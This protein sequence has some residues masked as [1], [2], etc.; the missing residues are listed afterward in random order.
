MKERPKL[1]KLLHLLVALAVAFMIVPAKPVYADADPID[2]FVMDAET[3]PDGSIGVLFVR[4]GSS[5]D[6]VISGG[7]LWYGVF[8][9][10]GDLQ[11]SEEAVGSETGAKEAALAI[12][13]GRAHIAYTTDNNTI[14]YIYQTDNGWSEPTEFGSNNVYSG[15]GTVS[16]PDIVIGSDGSV[17]IAYFDTEGYESEDGKGYPEVM[18]AVVGDTVV[19]SVVFVGWGW[20]SSPDG[21]R[22][23]PTTPVKIVQTAADYVNVYS[24]TFW[25][26]YYG[27]S[28]TSYYV[29]FT[30]IGGET[31]EI[32]DD[33][34]KYDIYEACSNGSD[35]Y[36]LGYGRG[37][38][39][40]LVY[41]GSG[42]DVMGLKSDAVGNYAADMTL[43]GSGT[44]YYSAANGNSILF[45]QNG[46]A[47]VKALQNPIS[48]KKL[49]TVLSDGIQY[50]IFTN[51][52]GNIVVA[53]LDDGE[54]VELLPTG[55]IP[56]D[57]SSVS[58]TATGYDSGEI[59]GVTAGGGYVVSY[60]TSDGVASRS[61]L[62]MGGGETIE[63]TGLVP[64]TV[65]VIKKAS[66]E[67]NADSAPK[68][69]EITRADTPALVAAQPAVIDG[70]GSIP[71]DATH[72]YTTDD[73]DDEDAQWESCTGE[74]TDLEPGTYYVRVAAS[75]TV[76]TSDPQEIELVDFDPAQ[77]D[78]P[79][80]TFTATGSSSGTL[81]G[82]VSG[83]TYAFDD[84][85]FTVEAAASSYDM[86]ELSPG[87]YSLVKC[88]N[89]ETTI[90][91]DEQIFTIT[92]AS[93][94]E[95][96]G[97]NPAAIGGN[98][99]INTDNTHEYVTADPGDDPDAADWTDCGGVLEVGAGTYYIRVK[100]DQTAL[101]SNYVTVTLTDPSQEVTPAATFTAT[102]SAKGTLSG[103]IAGNYKISLG[104]VDSTFVIADGVTTHDLT[105]LSAGKLMLVRLGDN[106][107]TSV[108]SIPQ[109]ITI[110]K[111]DTPA[112]SRVNPSNRGRKGSIPTTAAYEYRSESPQ[113]NP[114]GVNWI[115][116]AGA[117]TGLEAGDYYIRVAASQTTLASDVQHI[118][119]ETENIVVVTFDANGH[120][121]AP[122]PVEIKS[123]DMVPEPDP[124]PAA[125]GY[126]FGGWYTQSECNEEHKWTFTTR[127]T[128]DSTFYAKWTPVS[129]TVKFDKNL[130]AATGSMEDQARK[131]DDGI[132]LTACT[133][134]GPEGLEFAGW[135]LVPEGTGTIY[136]DGAVG[137][138]AT[139]DGAKVTLYATWTEE[140]WGDIVP[141]D[142]ADLK[143]Q[144]IRSNR[145]PDGVWVGK[146]EDVP[147]T[148]GNITLSADQLHVYDGK[149]LLTEG[150]DYTTRYSNQKNVGNTAKV[151]MIG[152]GNYGF[153]YYKEFSIVPTALLTGEPFAY[154]I[155]DMKYK[156]GT[157][158]KSKPTIKF[159]RLTLKE[160]TDY[161][162]AYDPENPVDAGE[163]KVT[164]T[165]ISS[166]KDAVVITYHIVTAETTL[167]N[168][169]IE[170]DEAYPLVYRGPD[171]PV[172]PPV[173]VKLNKN[174]DG[175]IP[176]TDE[177]TGKP[178][179]E[180][181]YDKCDN[182]GKG[183]VWVVGK[184]AYGGSKSITITI[185]P[186]PLSLHPE[187][188]ANVLVTGDTSY[189]G[190]AI[191]PEIE[192]LD[193]FTAVPATDYSVTY[194][195]NTNRAS[196]TETTAA[197]KDIA[198]TVTVKLKGNYSGTLTKKFAITG[199][200]LAGEDLE[201][202]VP[203]VKLSKANQ[204]IT[205]AMIKPTV[206]YGKKTLKKGTD[207]SVDFA[208]SGGNV[209]VAMITLQGNYANKPGV[210]HIDKPFR[211]YQA[212]DVLSEAD[213]TFALSGTS[214]TYTGDKI[215]PAVT[216]TAADHQYQG[217]ALKLV[218]GRD[219]TVS[220]S[221]NVNASVNAPANKQPTV[222]VKGKGAYK[223]TLTK[224]F[225]IVPID[226]DTLGVD[227]WSVSVPDVK[228]TGKQLSPKVT[229]T[230]KGK[231]LKAADYSLA[232]EDTTVPT[233][234]EKAKVTVTFASNYSG[235]KEGH[236]RVYKTDIT[237]MTFEKIADRYYTGTSVR[238]GENDSPQFNAGNEIKIYK[239]NKKNAA[240]ALVYGVDYTLE[241]EENIA[242]GRGTVYIIGIGEY[243]NRKA[244]TFKIKQRNSHFTA[245]IYSQ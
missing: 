59:G 129:Y 207:Y 216:I 69:F 90:D 107:V 153:N 218:E 240:D 210:E 26:K 37:N 154:T 53:Y 199:L 24:T 175:Y 198:P 123:G 89:Y 238:P 202:T 85:E 155:K 41:N 221:N 13:D 172:H 51:T 91:S 176:L 92:K 203:D 80:A 151:T 182:A 219:Y 192:V 132:A 50:S 25:E 29:D 2:G 143:A 245:R 127:L 34:K 10:D 156:A 73:P 121:T 96:T 170:L 61:F 150:V 194:K 74:L 68:E 49:T 241:W 87:E 137:N 52:D 62:I 159:G 33:W 177:E 181:L 71:T 131:Y 60:P 224:N 220:Y 104:G 205:A 144:N 161:S 83:A 204:Q 75:D 56:E 39:A 98:G 133:F 111:A 20:F 43:D 130:A 15:G 135:S 136:F 36:A 101:A 84:Y 115:A 46:A 122:A 184:N 208:H 213:F 128:G 21:N 169:V 6:G 239:T 217:A 23:F 95:L 22:N 244:L 206:K 152:K 214:F 179:Y 45:D 114:D 112:L 119:L 106:G 76:L 116:C 99:S 149:K 146:I 65:S 183:T 38:Y 109:E 35:V 212:Q 12:Y 211:A 5:S 243:G 174:S 88:G 79:T 134:E 55:L 164:V 81:S 4:G 157:V 222:T 31:K 117:L 110:T 197:G 235:T 223:G 42:A 105:G 94:P 32:C 72:E 227:E 237:R 185:A 231:T 124:A 47:V 103:L 232:Y 162:L 86:T 30:P 11:W 195:N 196:A 44:I 1:K 27:G 40:I 142:V 193:G 147:F 200:Q 168:A 113:G 78:T 236:F 108:D 229:V 64:G 230:V 171:N 226:V 102:G 118:T 125:T 54:L 67:I 57:V 58:F 163:V 82:L 165:G 188:V 166:F 126:I 70:K 7:T 186:K 215:T 209:Y 120:G 9:P 100:P 173:R 48:H 77:E 16:A 3:L 138:F 66:S 63:L 225:T 97:T 18:N 233:G 167:N 160:D 190:S 28:D 140:D 191:K 139:A 145:I 19:K 8:D 141:A 178:N 93:A 17:H 180:V 148:G 158:Q 201:I 234:N 14:A 187:G 189:T 228:C 242:T